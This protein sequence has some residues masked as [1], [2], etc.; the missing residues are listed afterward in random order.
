M[1]EMIEISVQIS[2]TVCY[3][4]MIPKIIDADSY[5]GVIRRL[6]SIHGMIPKHKLS[7]ATPQTSILLKLELE[8]SEDVLEVYSTTTP[9][10]F[11][12]YIGDKYGIT[13]Y[14]RAKVVSL[15]GRVRKRVYKMREKLK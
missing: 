1:V 14:P 9:E 10:A 2:D 12:E 3:D 11:S 5:P 13:D 15:I 8:E 7:G 4:I 6:K